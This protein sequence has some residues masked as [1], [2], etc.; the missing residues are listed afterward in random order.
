MN[1]SIQKGIYFAFA[2]SFISGV[3]IFLNKFAVA[4]IKP[5]LFFTTTKNIVVGLVLVSIVIA[6]RKLPQIRALQK[7]D[8]FRL[9]LIALIGGSLPFYL[10]FTGLTS[11]P[12]VNAAIIQKSLVVWVAILAI[13]FLKEK[14]SLLGMLAIV[15]LF[16][17]NTYIGGFSGLT[18]S[19]GE[20]MILG[21]TILWAIENV[22]AKKALQNIDADIVSVARMGMGSVFLLGALGVTHP[23]AL[24]SIGSFDQTQWFWL[25]ITSALLVGYVMTW[26]RALARA[27]ATTVTA[28]L[29]L[30]TVIT[31][32]LSAIFVTHT[33][34]E[35]MGVQVLLISMGILMAYISA[36]KYSIKSTYGVE[37][38]LS[39]R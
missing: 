15:L 26:Y 37:S 22:I 11:V 18:F 23:T 16:V 1:N 25:G 4:S 35:G 28:I 33:W 8:I 13:P 29:V 7:A 32:V 10:F 19:T 2:T 20:Y 38:N 12:A 31:N 6:L 3:S 27:P 21:A 9:V 34:T 5:P 36:R 30:S 39:S 24:A 14:F 17:G